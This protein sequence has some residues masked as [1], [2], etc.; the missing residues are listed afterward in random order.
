MTT[1]TVALLRTPEKLLAI[2]STRCSPFSIPRHGDWTTSD[3]YREVVHPMAEAKDLCLQDL[4]DAWQRLSSV[5]PTLEGFD[6][7]TIADIE[8]VLSATITS[9][10]TPCSRAWRPPCLPKPIRP[11]AANPRAF[12]GTKFQ[13][14]TPARPEA[15][16]LRPYLCNSRDLASIGQAI[17]AQL[18]DSQL[19]QT[20]SRQ[21]HLYDVPNAV[22]AAFGML[23]ILGVDQYARATGL[24]WDL[25][26]NRKPAL[27]CGIR[28]LI[29]WQKAP[30]DFEFRWLDVVKQLPPDRQLAMVELL[31]ESRA[32]RP[33]SDETQSLFL[34]LNELSSD[35]TFCD[36]VWAFFES[37]RYSCNLPSLVDGMELANA[38]S[39]E[40]EFAGELT[41]ESICI[42]PI[43][44]WIEHV[45]LEGGKV[46]WDRL[47]AALQIWA[48]C[49]I[50]PGFA[51]L[52]EQRPWEG[53]DRDQA[54]ESL[55]P[56]LHCQWTD[57][58]DEPYA[59]G[60]PQFRSR[61][62]EYFALIKALPE[63]HQIKG[64]KIFGSAVVDWNSDDA[65]VLLDRVFR[66]VRRVC[67]PPFQADYFNLVFDELVCLPEKEFESLLEVNDRNFR[68][69][70]RSCLSSNNRTLI[71]SGMQTMIQLA[72]EMFGRGFRQCP[73]LLFRTVRTLGSMADG[74]RRD[75]IR[76]WLK[77]PML[78]IDLD[79]PDLNQLVGDVETLR[80]TGIFNPVPAKLR[81]YVA[82]QWHLKSDQLVRAK[83]KL[84]EQ[85]FESQIDLLNHVVTEILASGIGLPSSETTNAAT[86][87]S[88]HALNQMGRNR[89][90]LRKFLKAHFAGR[91]GYR[92]NHP[93]NQKWLAEHHSV[94]LVKWRHGIS[95]SKVFDIG[96]ET[97]D[98]LFSI[99]Q[100]PLEVLRMG[101]YVGSCLGVGGIMDLLESAASVVPLDINKTIVYARNQR[102]KVVARQLL[103]ISD[104][105]RLVCFQVYPETVTRDVKQAFVG[106]ISMSDSHVTLACNCSAEAKKKS[107]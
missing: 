52:L 94:D 50:L 77:H 72:P 20:I 59:A 93:L 22:R 74:A 70:E 107:Q 5:T 45:R 24:Y 17:E 49:D 103:A 101:T 38:Y 28:R 84:Q 4:E 104:C 15:Y 58:E 14:P 21:L 46:H 57:V 67:Q 37:D 18:P 61:A 40:F 47:S 105:D 106:S 69:L 83:V 2:S 44:E 90:G 6:E 66:L 12:R 76:L 97:F 60:Y 68:A 62:N 34:R 3:P 89:R 53:L 23:Y 41:E 81:R 42:D 26:L 31:I 85:V 54:F 48:A 88:I 10:N 100:D 27:C 63:S 43:V 71:A 98:L 78:Q 65:T 99:E 35:E 39:P 79:Q 87:H 51:K 9:D 102:G 80:P 32:I 55:Q 92:E 8:E 33:P 11:T 95:F 13:P 25:E 91:H 96:S 56:F 86:R 36:R 73:K 1:K 75:A 82:G 30:D 16:D 64:I 7:P 19:T 29:D